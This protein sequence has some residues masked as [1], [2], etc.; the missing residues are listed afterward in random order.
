MPAEPNIND[1]LASEAEATERGRDVDT[2]YVRNT[3]RSKDPA[4]VYSVRL[5]MDRLEELR[6]LATRQHVAPSALIRRW[7]IERLDRE[8][9]H[10]SRVAEARETHG[11]DGD[12][13]LM[14]TR[15]QFD[16]LVHDYLVEHAD[17][18]MRLARDAARGQ[19]K[20]S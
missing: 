7:V 6:Q 2:H 8:L 19:G 20:E 14:V 12:E 9:D 3:T 1:I 13:V 16:S 11:R 10:A 15:D 18:I 5:P 4:Q 17:M